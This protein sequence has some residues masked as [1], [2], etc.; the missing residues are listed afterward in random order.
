[1]GQKLTR[2]WEHFQLHL[3]QNIRRQDFTSGKIISGS[4]RREGMPH[5]CRSV[6]TPFR[7]L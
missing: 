7:V 5:Y 1:M 4:G 2:Q 3:A 6:D